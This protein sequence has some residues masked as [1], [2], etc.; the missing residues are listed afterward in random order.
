VAD[1]LSM[2]PRTVNVHLTSIYSKIGVTSRTAATR[3][4]LENHL[5]P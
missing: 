4:A 2:A 3:Y 5:V 1:K